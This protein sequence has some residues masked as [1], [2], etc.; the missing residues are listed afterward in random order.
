M[1]VNGT[2]PEMLEVSPIN[3][4]AERFTK[5]LDDYVRTSLP[6]TMTNEEYGRATAAMLLALNRTLATCSVAFGK[7]HGVDRKRIETHM[8]INFRDNLTLAYEASEQGAGTV[9]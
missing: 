7:T 4:F 6:V 1:M 3:A 8:L 2:T 5:E 9:Q